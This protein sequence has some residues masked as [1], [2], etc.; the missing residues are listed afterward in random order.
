MTRKL[1]VTEVTVAGE[2]VHIRRLNGSAHA[3][4]AVEMLDRLA[5]EPMLIVEVGALLAVCCLCDADGKPEYG[6]PEV[7]RQNEEI[8]FLTD[9]AKAALEHSGLNDDASKLSKNS[10]AVPSEDSSSG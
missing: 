2:T 4:R 10:P 8:L 6:D 5:A 1:K 3:V 9:F 7:V